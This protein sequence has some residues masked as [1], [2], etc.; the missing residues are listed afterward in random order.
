MFAGLLG[1]CLLGP[2]TELSYD[3]GYWTGPHAGYGVYVPL[4]NRNYVP[5]PT[6]IRLVGWWA[7]PHGKFDPWVVA[8]DDH[9]YTRLLKWGDPRIKGVKKIA[10]GGLPWLFSISEELHYE[11]PAQE[12]GH[13]KP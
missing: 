5:L 1:L 4:V 13:A 10:P 9:N 8:L 12:R 11:V 3:A 2:G 7:S 6:T